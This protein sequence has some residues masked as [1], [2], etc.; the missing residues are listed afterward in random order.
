ML[1][2]LA[3][4]KENVLKPGKRKENEEEDHPYCKASFY[5][6]KVALLPIGVKEQLP[7]EETGSSERMR[8]D[9]IAVE[10]RDNKLETQF[11]SLSAH[12]PVCS[13]AK[14]HCTSVICVAANVKFPHGVVYI[15]EVLSKL[16]SPLPENRIF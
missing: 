15:V 8:T 14:D 13:A 7:L 4:I 11:T 10:D 1:R 3:R 12:P 16:C 6:K 5:D 2:G 9:R